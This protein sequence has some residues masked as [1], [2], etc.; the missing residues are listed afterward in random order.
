MVPSAGLCLGDW[1]LI[2]VNGGVAISSIIDSEE[3]RRWSRIECLAFVGSA[4]EPISVQEGH[5][6]S[7]P[8][9]MKSIRLG[10]IC[11]TRMMDSSV[12][13]SRIT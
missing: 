6:W 5:D 12:T 10:G 8:T 11:S 9:H 1:I 4:E 3:G 2:V 7:F 13:V